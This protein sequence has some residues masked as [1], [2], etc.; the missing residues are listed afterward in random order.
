MDGDH[1]LLENVNF[2]QT[3]HSK[4]ISLH[5]A[6]T[7]VYCKILWHPYFTMLVE[8]D[9]SQTQPWPSSE[10]RQGHNLDQLQTLQ[11]TYIYIYML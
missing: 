3:T 5:T 4:T 7:I 10:L 2:K 11:H 8:L 6:T 9:Q 1:P